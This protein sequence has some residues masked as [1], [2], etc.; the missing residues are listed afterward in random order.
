MV[1]ASTAQV[2]AVL[3][4]QMATLTKVSTALPPSPSGS[5]FS[6]DRTRYRT[7]ITACELM[8]SLCPRTYGSDSMK[9]RSAISLLSG[10]LDWA[11]AF[12]ESNDHI[13]NNYEEFVSTL[14][15]V[16]NPSRGTNPGDGGSNQEH[17]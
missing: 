11:T 7:F 17:V 9:V 5:R 1:P 3:T 4:E 6:G 13:I 12:W 14:K 15:S 8:F 16:F 2:L 10:A